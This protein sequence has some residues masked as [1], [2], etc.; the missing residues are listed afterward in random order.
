VRDQLLGLLPKDYDVATSAKPEEI[1]DLFG[2]R[3]TIP[4][5]AAF[6]VITVLG[7]RNAGSIEVATF[8]GESQYLDGRHPSEVHFTNAKEDAQRRDFTINGL[9]F[10]PIN[11]EVIDYVNGER[12]L[13]NH[14]VRAIGDPEARLADD[15]LRM[16]RAVRFAA[17]FKFAIDG[18]TRAAIVRHAAEIHQVSA[19]RIGMEL[20][21]MLLDERRA[22]ALKELDACGL[23]VQV[24]P[25]V[26]RLPEDVQKATRAAMRHLVEPTLPL[27]LAAMLHRAGAP[28]VGRIVSR[29]LKFTNKEAER[30][31]WLL[32]Q[33]EPIVAADRL[34]WPQL[35]RILTHE[36]GPEL[37]Q[38]AAAIV[39]DSTAVNLCRE[40]LSQP[41]SEL[42]PPPLVDGGD[43]LAAGVT[44]GPE[45]GKLLELIRDEQLTGTLTSREAALALVAQRLQAKP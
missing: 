25:E 11:S 7:P 8:R 33:L 39:G 12:D 36:G 27:A 23:L 6:G 24:L 20:R 13:A 41:L 9:F 19:E 22:S 35:Q 38:L 30:T 10:D 43:L 3:R 34:P 26:A 29:R 1:R 2:Q 4:V 28:E 16:L 42:N 31:E 45:I 15:K 37:V 32:L 18:N 21:R 40:K 17:T 5:G 14:I 44:A